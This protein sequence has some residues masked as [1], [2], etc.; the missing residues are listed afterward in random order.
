[1]EIKIGKL[2]QKARPGLSV[3]V[4]VC[5]CITVGMLYLLEK[6]ERAG[7]NINS[8]TFYDNKI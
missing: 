7:L 5:L 8:I 6:T 2:N 1:M 3:F 4:I